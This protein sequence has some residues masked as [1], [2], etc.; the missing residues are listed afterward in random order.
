[1]PNTNHILCSQH[2][3]TH[4]CSLFSSTSHLNSSCLS[5]ITSALL[6][7]TQHLLVAKPQLINKL[8]EVGAA[9]IEEGVWISH[10]K[11]VKHTW[12]WLR[13]PGTLTLML[14]TKSNLPQTEKGKPPLA[15]WLWHTSLRAHQMSSPWL[16]PLK[17]KCFLFFF[18]L[19]IKKREN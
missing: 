15:P 14:R 4:P 3:R 19:K 12:F 9:G 13:V 5:Q 11:Q 17:K 1:M 16:P 6:Q 2:F 10:H 7:I 8:G 18:Q